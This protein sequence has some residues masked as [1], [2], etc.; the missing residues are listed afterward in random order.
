M[1]WH[2][3]M[4]N[5]RDYKGSMDF[6]HSNS[7]AISALTS[8]R[9]KVDEIWSLLRYQILIS[10][11]H[12]K[13]LVDLKISPGERQKI[14]TS[15]KSFIDQAENFYRYAMSADFRSAPL[16][17]YYSFLNLAKALLVVK[18]PKSYDK[19]FTHGIRSINTHSKLINRSVEV[20]I[21]SKNRFSVFNETY[22]AIY[23][24]YLPKNTKLNL[25]DILGYL[26]DINSETDQLIPRI[27]NK[28]HPVRAYTIIDEEYAW[29][30]LRTSTFYP[31]NF[32]KTYSKFDAEFK[33]FQ[34]GALSLQFTYE[35]PKS[36]S[37]HYN[38]SQSKT[39]WKI[40][41]LGIVP[42]DEIT[43]YLREVFGLNIQDAIYENDTS[44]FIS[45]PLRKSWQT[46]FNEVLAIHTFMFYLSELVRYYPA[47]FEESL[48][49]S[50]VE[51]WVVKNFVESTPYTALVE[52]VSL[53]TGITYCIK[54][55]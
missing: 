7:N 23:G 39:K 30:V 22:N 21:S 12:Q 20:A 18:Y 51:G 26:S 46:P 41:S 6:Y 9:S 44:F 35:M 24:K 29:C 42:T 11:K 53:I 34:P 43:Q 47:E 10:D 45:D 27:S 15:L 2:T 32:K 5:E 37:I 38:F 1:A 13:E 48:S 31:A 55:R 50:N 17:Y 52:Y 28:L 8:S 33:R 3:E 49:P 40:G 25:H 4:E 36:K 14:T 19:K 16:L 54:G